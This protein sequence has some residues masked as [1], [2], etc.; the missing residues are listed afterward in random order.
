MA[1]LSDLVT[2][3]STDIERTSAAWTPRIKDAIN[4]A[5]RFYNTK[6]FYFN[7]SRTVTFNTVAGTET[8]TFNTPTVTGSIGAEFNRIDA[9]FITVGGNT[10]ELVRRDYDWLES[11]ADNNT[12][13]GQPYNYAYINRGIRIYPKPNIVYAVRILGHQKIAAPTD[14][15]DINNVWMNEGFELIRSVAK[16]ALAVHVLEDDALAGR[17]IQAEKKALSALRSE[18]YD[19]IGDGELIPTNW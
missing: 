6:R 17:M 3:I 8:Y 5:V 16:L 13:Q 19:K 12:S 4:D 18:T 10:V 7:E 9:I 2:R 11:L 14:D 1:V 15:T